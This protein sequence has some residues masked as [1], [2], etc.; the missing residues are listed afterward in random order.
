[1]TVMRSPSTFILSGGRQSRGKLSSTSPEHARHEHRPKHRVLLA[2]GKPAERNQ[3]R[4]LF[5]E[6][7]Y[8]VTVADNGRE[9]LGAIKAGGLD[10]VIA[11]VIMDEIDGIELVRSAQT[12]KDAPP[13]IVV[14]R[15]HSA[16]DH[17]YLRSAALAGAAA[18]YTQP[19]RTNDFLAG[20]LSALTLKRSPW[21]KS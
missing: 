11:A 21:I 1:M 7:E 14:S 5:S 2:N 6:E 18:T 17:A 15:G 19:L 10:L 9:A 4:S 8:L 13:I 16:L 12:I 20:I 3:W